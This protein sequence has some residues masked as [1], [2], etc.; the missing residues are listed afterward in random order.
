MPMEVA[1]LHIYPVKS[2]RGIDVDTAVMEKRGFRYD[3][4][5][6]IVGQDGV[7][8]TQR[9]IARM[10]LFDTDL[11]SSALRIGVSGMRDLEAPLKPQGQKRMVKVWRSWV[12][13]TQVWEEADAW[14]TEAMGTPCSLVRLSES[15]RRT[16]KGPDARSTDI[17][18]FA[19]SNPILLASESSL[20]DLNKRLQK[21][22]P[23]VRFRPNIVVRGS[24][25]WREDDWHSVQL[26]QRVRLRQTRLCGRCIVTTIDPATA[27][28]SDEPLRTLATFRRQ[29]K[30]VIF[31][32]HFAPDGLGAVSIGDGVTVTHQS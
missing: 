3:R 32:T 12:S 21:P 11:T 10:A 17:V 22:L 4:R 2:L 31:G 19:D 14:L 15:S 30:N 13:A 1:S 26:G 25:P 27:E 5:W 18:G 24:D 9:K 7:F 6:M 16:A 20:H 28:L 23:M 8:F 29:G